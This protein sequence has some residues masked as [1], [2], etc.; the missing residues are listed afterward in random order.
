MKTL[1]TALLSSAFLFFGSALHAEN[2]TYAAPVIVNGKPIVSSEI[3]DAIRAQEHFVRMQQIGGPRKAEARILQ[4][5]AGALFSLVEQRLVLSEFEQGRG[6]VKPQ[7]IDDDIN[8][9]VR[10]KFGGDRKQFLQELARVGMTLQGFREQREQ[11]MI[12]SSLCSSR[13]KNLPP[14]TPAQVEA[15]Y[16]KHSEMFRGTDYIKLSTITIPKYQVGDAAATPETQ[17]MFAEDI[18]KEIRS[19]ADFA[20]MARTHSTD[21]YAK[22]SGDRGLQ[23]RASLSKEIGDVAFALNAGG[24]SQVVDADASYMIVYCETKQPGKQEPLDKVRP[25]IEKAIANEMARE[26]VN[27]WLAG[28]ANRTVIQPERVRSDFLQWLGHREAVLD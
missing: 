24:V 5:R 26:E 28:L 25:L 15:Y 19:G 22:S 21:T 27:R 23:E 18:R 7:Y 4:I 1:P 13:T 12:V 14:P 8:K 10:E 6:V 2:Q 3:R 11:M 17:K 9:L 16:R 20:Q